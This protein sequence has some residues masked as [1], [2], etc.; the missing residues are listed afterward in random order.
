MTF[1]SSHRSKC[2]ASRALAILALLL[3][4]LDAVVAQDGLID[5]A[6]STSLETLEPRVRACLL[7]RGLV[8][9]GNTFRQFHQ[10]YDTG[11]PAFLTADPLIDAAAHSLKT[12]AD[13]IE[14]RS[15]KQVVEYCHYLFDYWAREETAHARTL[16]LV[17]A[18]ASLYAGAQP[19]PSSSREAELLEM[20]RGLLASEKGRLVYISVIAL[21]VSRRHQPE[22][23]PLTPH[24]A[25]TRAQDFLHGIKLLLDVPSQRE[26]YERYWVWVENDE[27]AAS[28]LARTLRPW[29]L[30][31]GPIP[32]ERSIAA[33]FQAE[34]AGHLYPI[35][36]PIWARLLDD[37]SMKL[38]AH[39]EVP[40]G[41]D[42]LAVGPLASATG[43]RLWRSRFGG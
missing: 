43:R 34:Q 28:L 41:L 14:R 3:S 2:G 20:A 32:R 42:L 16:A 17:G 19:K 15:Q 8:L 13:D 18:M 22:A 29:E 39:R 37:V 5:G 26:I 4:P 40:S 31:L 33:S 23:A 36:V 38:P 9:S 10:A 30:L 11:L 27:Y 24:V 1:Y 25:A 7:E 35:S 6:E 12:L 21:P